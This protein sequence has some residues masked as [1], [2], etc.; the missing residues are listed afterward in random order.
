MQRPIRLL[1][2]L[3][4]LAPCLLFSQNID[5][6]IQQLPAME[7]NHDKVVALYQLYGHFLYTD[8][9]SAEYYL[10]EGETLSFQIDD[11][12]GIVL[13]Y[14]KRAGLA[15]N[16][17]AYDEAF[18]YLRKADSL[19]QNMDWP[20]EQAIIYGN[21]A[22]CYKDIGQLDSALAWNERFIQLA[23]EIDNQGFIAYGKTIAGDLYQIK[24]QQAL[25]GRNYLDAVRVYEQIPDTVRLADA[26]RALGAS[27]I[28]YG[29]YVEGY[30][31]LEKAIDIYKKLEDYYYLSQ[32]YRDVAQGHFYQEEYQEA[33][34]Y[35]NQ[36]LELTVQIEDIYGESQS[37]KGIAKNYMKL[38]KLDT[39][40]NIGLRALDK[41]ETIENPIEIAGAQRQL[42]EIYFLRE[43]YDLALAAYKKAESYI[44]KTNVPPVLHDIYRGLYQLY[45]AKGQ[46]TEALKA[47]EK[48]TMLSDSIFSVEKSAQLEELQLIYNVEKKDQEIKIL[49]QDLALG[50]L[51]RQLLSLALIGLVIIAGLIVYGQ[52][53]RRKKEKAIAYEKSQRQ[54]A[55][56]EKEQIEKAQVERELTAQVLQL[57]RKNELLL[58]V[59]EEVESLSKETNQAQ[60]VR[61]LSRT[62]SRS[63]ES[64]QDW[65]QFLST[66]ERVHPDFLNQL[67]LENQKL[68]PADQRLACLLKMNLSSKEI[69]TMLSISDE[70]VKKARYRLRKKLGLSS[71]MNLQEYLLNY[72][73]GVLMV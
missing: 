19:L 50:S 39:A 1:C 51:R 41:Y 66:F 15:M 26:L 20:R 73:K 7:A 17:S 31:N 9:D 23:R 27:Q 4:Y 29:S 16:R 38:G 68:S 55:E 6:L 12:Q 63:L 56:L 35:G 22:G 14:D 59:K 61:K 5:S 71:D 57:C 42:G 72:E 69:A 43:E 11:Q 36:S 46:S 24:G 64:D 49:T 2:L 54:K 52:F 62:I 44:D 10:E 28:Y 58:N 33:I 34:S 48:Y 60:A 45:N 21:F 37:L 13:A 70:G 53:T 18:I 67:N 8:P 65:Q 47:F 25:A 3:F 40:L 32:A 30:D